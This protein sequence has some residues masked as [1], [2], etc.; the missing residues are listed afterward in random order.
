M[1][2][3]P[4]QEQGPLGMDMLFP[5][6]KSIKPGGL[7]EQKNLRSGMAITHIGDEVGERC[8]PST[9]ACLS[10]DAAPERAATPPR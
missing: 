2:R 6:I 9:A 1:M 5:F 10:R 4:L 3:G 7:A 8:S